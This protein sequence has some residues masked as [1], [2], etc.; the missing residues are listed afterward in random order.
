MPNQPKTAASSFRFTPAELATMDRLAE[1][2]RRAADLHRFTRSDVLRLALHRLA[3]S[4]LG[5][6][7][8]LGKNR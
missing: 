8:N 6:K 7:K 5:G 3:D 1:H 4:E 2:L